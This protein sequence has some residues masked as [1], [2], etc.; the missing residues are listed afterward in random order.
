MPTIT[1]CA[2]AAIAA[3]SSSPVPRVP[4]DKRIALFGLATSTSPD[5]AAIS[6]TA[7]RPSPS[8]PIRADNRLASGS[9]DAG[10]AVTS[11][12]S[13]RPGLR[14]SLRRRRPSGPG[15]SMR[16]GRPR[17]TARHRRAA[18]S[19]DRLP[20]NLSGAITTR[21]AAGPLQAR[22]PC[23]AAA[24]RQWLAAGSIGVPCKHNQSAESNPRGTRRG[25]QCQH[26]REIPI[27]VFKRPR[28]AP[29]M[30]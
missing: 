14:P 13:P 27:E 20:L 16:P 8:R 2:P 24:R 15:R 30:N 3:R 19:A 6:I 22:R 4:R 23:L 7:V 11:R 25:I 12:R 28:L 1:R 9:A 29:G 5:A 21:M 18:S 26:S 17:H 10:F